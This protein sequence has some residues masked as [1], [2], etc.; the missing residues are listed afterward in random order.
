LRKIK[1]KQPP[2]HKNTVE[3][4]REEE[5]LTDTDA[6]RPQLWRPH[7]KLIGNYKVRGGTGLVVA[8]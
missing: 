2:F 7:I 3:M 1:T 6:V 4:E 5:A 8:W